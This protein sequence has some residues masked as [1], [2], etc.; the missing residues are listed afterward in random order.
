MGGGGQGDILQSNISPPPSK[1]KER[2]LHNNWER[3]GGQIIYSYMFES[4]KFRDRI[5]HVSFGWEIPGHPTPSVL[6]MKVV[7]LYSSAYL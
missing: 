7:F 4:T 6:R 3:T 2:D 1:K 5:I